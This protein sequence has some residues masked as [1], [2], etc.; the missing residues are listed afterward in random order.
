MR[1]LEIRKTLSL[2]IALVA[3]GCGSPQQIGRDYTRIPYVVCVARPAVLEAAEPPA[4]EGGG[5][6]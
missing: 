3:L 5:L 2:T 4:R 1:T 6:R